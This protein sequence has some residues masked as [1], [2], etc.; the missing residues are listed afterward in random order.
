M[1]IRTSPTATFQE[2]HFS[3]SPI[4]VLDLRIE[5]TSLEPVL[6]EFVEELGRA[7]IRLR[8]RFHL[9]TEWGVAPGSIAIGIPFYL[10]R[11]ELTR[12]HIERIGHV[13]GVGRADL[14]RY[15][16]HEMG[17]VVNHAYQLF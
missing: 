15:L 12:L 17:H 7:G 16:R 1:S 6:A 14:L 4:R 9:S 3:S 11:P 5:G 2:T 10:A 8:P 13:E